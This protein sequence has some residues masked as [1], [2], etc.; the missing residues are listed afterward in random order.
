MNFKG[1]EKLSFIDY[2]EKIC[3]V[4]FTGGCNFRC[5]YCHNSPLIYNQGET[6]TECF[7][8]DYL[9]KRKKILDAVCISGGEPTL[10]NTLYSFIQKIKEKGFLVKLDTNGTHPEILKKLIKE[11]L[12]DYIAM[13]IKAPFDKYPI[14]TRKKISIHAIKESI[15]LLQ[16]SS[17]DYEFRTTLC[18]E[19]LTQEDILKIAE[20]LKGS[21]RYFLQNFKDGS[22]IL[23]GQNK[24]QPF[25]KKELKIIEEQIKGYFP[26]FKIRN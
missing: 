4:L 10:H 13:D 25:S 11:N 2:P 22:T 9:E 1:F 23:D 19:L 24:F 26:L 5:P 8:F 14:V 16:Q 15:D 7:V 21:K 17:I 18:K 20:Y 6:I 12:V 3:T